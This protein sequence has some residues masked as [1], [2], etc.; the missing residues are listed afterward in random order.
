[1]T[2]CNKKI[3]K[4][5]EEN[6]NVLPSYA[7]PG[8]YPIFYFDAEN[9]ILCPSCAMEN[10]DLSAP[11]VDFDINWEDSWLTCDQCGKK[12]QAAYGEE[13]YD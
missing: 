11:V 13:E 3:K 9:N 6:N 2:N 4:I 7:W 8:G 5:I 10:D 12:I 1:M